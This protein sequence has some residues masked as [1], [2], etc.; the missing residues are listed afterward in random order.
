[1]RFFSTLLVYWNI[2][3]TENW[4]IC[5]KHGSGYLC[6]GNQDIRSLCNVFDKW[7]KSHIWNHECRQ[8]VYIVMYGIIKDIDFERSLKPDW[9]VFSFSIRV[10]IL[11]NTL[12]HM[13]QCAKLPLTTWCPSFSRTVIILFSDHIPDSNEEIG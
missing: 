5:K 7:E 11:H 1:M 10:V 9:C 2:K 8:Y 6:N 3:Y 13:C 4:L 12:I